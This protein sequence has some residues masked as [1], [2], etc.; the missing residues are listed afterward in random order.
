MVT[1]TTRAKETLAALRASANVSD[2]DV[3]LRLDGS[4][5]AGFGLVP[6]HEKPGDQ[7]VEHGGAKV[8]LIDD[9]LADALTG[10][11]IDTKDTESGPHLVIATAEE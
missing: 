6:D 4:P 1:V 11:K 7:I 8:L 5:M 10:T 9:E 3:G 2:P